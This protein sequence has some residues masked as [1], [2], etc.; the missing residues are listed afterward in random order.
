MKFKRNLTYYFKQIQIK[1]IFLIKSENASIF[2]V[3]MTKGYSIA[4]PAYGRPNE[5]EELLGSIYEM[6]MMPDEVIICEDFSRERDEI[7]FIA[8]K[9]LTIFKSKNVTL[10]YIENQQNLGYD[11]NIRK[12]IDLASGKWVILIGNDDLFLRNGLTEIDAFCKRNESIAMISRPFIRFEKDINKPLGISRILQNETIIDKKDSAKLIF[13]MCGFVGGLV[14]N[15]EWAKNLATDKY[16]GTLFYQIY[17]AAHA[18]CTTGIGY[19]ANPSVGG[20]AG[21]P[22]LFGNSEKHGNVHVPGSYSAKGRALMW[23]G[24]LDIG[25]DVGDH[26]NIKLHEELQRELMVRQSFHVFE[27]NV[28]V[29]K[30]TLKELRSELRELNLFD[31]WI[32]KTLYF[33]NNNFG[34]N[35]YYVYYLTRKIMQ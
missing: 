21:N 22:P 34:K 2:N 33:L 11:A 25:K 26:Y 15:K 31:H 7:R 10:S 5:F 23:K 12:L 28:G 14:I 20:R 19:L 4:I 3:K 8:E 35:A 29:T 13:R 17:L 27:M 30:Q 6:D 16:D 18:F 1:I 9:Y 24:V 32:P